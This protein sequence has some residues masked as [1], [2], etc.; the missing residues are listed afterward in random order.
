MTT[1]V[2][3]EDIEPPADTFTADQVRALIRQEMAEADKAN[4]AVVDALKSQVA[5][6]QASMIGTI[7]VSVPKHAAGNGT[8]NEATW[9]KYEQELAHAAEVAVHVAR[10]ATVTASVL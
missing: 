3:P 9:S 10:L 4:A 5:S 8:D 7:P 1:P 2:N 6:L